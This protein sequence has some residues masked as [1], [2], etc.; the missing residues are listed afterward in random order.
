ML[1]S[2]FQVSSRADGT[3]WVAYL[4]GGCHRRS[5]T[6]SSLR[7]C[8]SFR[9]R[10]QICAHYT[11][12]IIIRNHQNSIGKNLGPYNSSPKPR[13]SQLL[14]WTNAGAMQVSQQDARDKNRH[15]IPPQT[16]SYYEQKYRGLNTY[17]HYSLL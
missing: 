16:P 10:G 14:D 5:R 7:S 4:R 13:T 6:M 15:C 8:T 1:I 2:W 12:N 11:T 17:L 3:A 9:C